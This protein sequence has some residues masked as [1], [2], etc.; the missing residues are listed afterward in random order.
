VDRLQ[1]NWGQEGLMFTPQGKGWAGWSM[2]AL[3]NQRSGGGPP[4]ASAPLRK[5]KGRVAELEQE[6]GLSLCLSCFCCC[7]F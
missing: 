3:V 7:N 4:T 2:P 5:G 6:V 1:N